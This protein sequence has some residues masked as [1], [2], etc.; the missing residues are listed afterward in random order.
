MKW[1]EWK[2][3]EREQEAKGCRR[4]I[5][6]DIWGKNNIKKMCRDKVYRDTQISS[7]GL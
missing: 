1:L 5:K 4:R 3:E 6:Q 7:E 2:I